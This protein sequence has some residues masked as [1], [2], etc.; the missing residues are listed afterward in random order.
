MYNLDLE[1]EIVILRFRNKYLSAELS[2][3]RQSLAV[4]LRWYY[5]EIGDLCAE[6]SRFETTKIVFEQKSEEV[7]G[8]DLDIKKLHRKLVKITHPDVS[9][10]AKAADYTRQVN[11]A[12]DR[13]DYLELLKL[14]QKLAGKKSQEQLRLEYN[15]LIDANYDVACKIEDC[16]NSSEYKLQQIFENYPNRESLILGIRLKL[17]RRIRETKEQYLRQAV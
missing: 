8:E 15:M 6:I 16:K 3:L 5:A 13:G 10:V 7:L 1:S 4:F 14:E 17:K 9:I 2:N 11:E 12:Y